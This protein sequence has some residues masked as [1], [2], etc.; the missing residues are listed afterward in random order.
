[1]KKQILITGG[2]GYIGYELCKIYSGSS[3]HDKIIV[4]D[5]NFFSERVKQLTDW[6]IE[7][8]QGD[9]LDYDFINKFIPNAD[10]IH[11]LAGI[12]NVAYVKSDQNLERDNLI[13]ST[14]IQGTNNILKLMKTNAKIIFPS[15]F[16]IFF[17]E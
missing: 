1:M 5:K 6:N 16:S 8:H 14:A 15:N 17:I 11:H 4:I 10:V 2:L 12:T 3:W 13:K 9:I 7:F